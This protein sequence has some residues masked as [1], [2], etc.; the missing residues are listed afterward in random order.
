MGDQTEDK[1]KPRDYSF[2]RKEMD[3]DRVFKQ[4]KEV[5]SNLGFEEV[6][7]MFREICYDQIAYWNDRNKGV[8]YNGEYSSKNIEQA[9]YLQGKISTAVDLYT[10]VL[11]HKREF[12]EDYLRERLGL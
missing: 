2:Y 6:C 9:T 3:I 12:D 8:V 11:I 1:L 7:K 10:Q 5:I 4:L